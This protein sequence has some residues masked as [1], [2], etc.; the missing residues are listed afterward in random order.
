MSPHLAS[1]CSPEYQQC[2][3]IVEEQIWTTFLQQFQVYNDKVALS[4]S[5]TF[6]GEHI[7]VGDLSFKFT[8]ESLS[9]AIELVAEGEPFFKGG[10][11]N[12]PNC[13]MFLNPSY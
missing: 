13:T 11:L 9:I 8:E 3:G 6:N 12:I 4:F 5:Q 2:K 1:L 7:K 10:K